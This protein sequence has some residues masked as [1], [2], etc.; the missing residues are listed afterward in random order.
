MPLRKGETF[1][2]PTSPPSSDQD[3]VLSIRSLPRRAPTSLDAITTNDQR[4]A[5]ILDRLTLAD[6]SEEKPSTKSKADLARSRANSAAGANDTDTKKPSNDDGKNQSS[7]ENKE[8]S[9]E[10]AHDSDSGLG[11]SISSVE[12]SSPLTKASKLTKDCGRNG[13]NEFS[14]LFSDYFLT[15]DSLVNENIHDQSAITTTAES[16]ESG[17]T[18]RRQ[19]GLA[20]CKHIE[21]FVLIPILKEP[22]LQPFHALARSIPSRIVKKQIVC[23]RDL[24]KTLL[25]LAPVSTHSQLSRIH[26][27]ED[28]SLAHLFFSF[29]P[30]EVDFLSTCLSQL[31][32]VYDPVFAHFSLA[33]QRPRPAITNRSPIH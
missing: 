8:V 30:I 10:E 25:W 6:S 32:R 28:S 5:S 2:T 7:S 33:S 20:A 3:P 21:K 16:F 13:I 1:N 17:S 23:L 26:A 11:S 18:P 24:E 19:L 14:L 22:K 12:S 27:L 15:F 31:R 29:S 9:S 4:M